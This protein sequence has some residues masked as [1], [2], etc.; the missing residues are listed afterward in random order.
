MAYNK[1]SAKWKVYSNEHLH[2]KKEKKTSSKQPYDVPQAPRKIRTS[3]TQNWQIK[4]ND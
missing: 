4:G 2:Q 3:R 1:G